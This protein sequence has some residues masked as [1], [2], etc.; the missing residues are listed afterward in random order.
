MQH[1]M[2]HSWQMVAAV[3]VLTGAASVAVVFLYRYVVRWRRRAEAL[4]RLME[5]CGLPSTPAMEKR[6]GAGPERRRLAA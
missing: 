5:V 4:K 6:S 3:A 1:S 2:Q